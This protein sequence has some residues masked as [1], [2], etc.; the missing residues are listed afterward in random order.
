MPNKVT[1]PEIFG[2]FLD[3]VR[4]EV[5]TAMPATV[6]A[7]YPD[8]QT[9]D[10]KPAIKNPLF[11][12]D[13]TPT[14]EELPGLSDIPLGVLRGGG[15]FVWI[16]VIPGDSV[17]L[18]FSKLS[19]DTWRS[20]SG[21]GPVAPSWVGKLGFGS[22][23]AVPLVAP[24]ASFFTDIATDPLKIIIGKDGSPAQVKLSATD[25]ELGG[26]TDAVALASK[27]DAL[28]QAIATCV[29]VPTDGGAAIK[30][31][32][33]AALAALA[34]PGTTASLIVKAGT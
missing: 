12:D 7:V 2:A 13:G 27:V 34:T 26:S 3:T 24:D 31:A 22:A 32:V 6:T 4:D 29:I 23:I 9:V 8:R 30:A 28:F 15:F 19:M 18:L 33:V 14:F 17:I 16:P 5:W 10:C 21:E 20:G 11:A 25:I 1:L